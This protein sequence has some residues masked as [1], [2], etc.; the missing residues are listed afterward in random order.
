ML[1]VIEIAVLV[2][3]RLRFPH[4]GLGFALL[5]DSRLDREWPLDDRLEN[6]VSNSLLIGAGVEIVAKLETFPGQAPPQVKKV[7]C[8]RAFIH[9]DR[10]QYEIPAYIMVPVEGEAARFICKDELV[11]HRSRPERLLNRVLIPWSEIEVH[12]KDASSPKVL[13]RCFPR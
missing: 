5:H 9:N 13:P 2:K 1:E 12:L 6:C 10:A 4:L 3:S 8:D 7:C 11:R